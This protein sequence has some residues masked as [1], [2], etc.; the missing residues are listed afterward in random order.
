MKRCAW[1][2]TF[3]RRGWNW[4]RATS[5]SDPKSALQ[6]VDEAPKQQKQMLAIDRTAKL[7]ADGPAQH[8]G[9]PHQPGCRTAGGQ[10]TGTGVAGWGT[11]ADGK[12]LRRG[13][14]SGE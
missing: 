13:T 1:T 11:Q 12:R 6:V 8:E 5:V 10:V 3:W 14:R 7:G 9:S 2:P 4:R